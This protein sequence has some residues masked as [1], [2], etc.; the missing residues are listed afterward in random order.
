M[1]STKYAISNAQ[2][3]QLQRKS[4]IRYRQNFINFPKISKFKYVNILNVWMAVGFFFAHAHLKTEN[5]T[6]GAELPLHIESRLT[7]QMFCLINF[8]ALCRCPTLVLASLYFFLVTL[9]H[10]TVTN[11]V[12]NVIV[13]RVCNVRWFDVIF[14]IQYELCISW[15][16]YV[17]KIVGRY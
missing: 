17:R 3:Q 11:R 1:Y 2:Q 8:A 16:Y 5:K 14:R 10:L 9:L 13:G 12:H 15:F 4:Q 7:N 6:N